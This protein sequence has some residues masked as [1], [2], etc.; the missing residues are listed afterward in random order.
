MDDKRKGPG[1]PCV[2]SGVFECSADFLFE[3]VI[4]NEFVAINHIAHDFHLFDEV[5]GIMA[6][7]DF[8]FQSEPCTMIMQALDAAIAVGDDNGGAYCGFHFGFSFLSFCF[9][10]FFHSL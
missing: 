2:L 6:N 8:F 5:S 3:I 1:G 10:C 9:P 7:F 4:I